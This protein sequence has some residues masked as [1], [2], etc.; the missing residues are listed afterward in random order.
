M[1]RT[2][3]INPFSGFPKTSE[4]VDKNG[5]RRFVV[6]PRAAGPLGAHIADKLTLVLTSLFAI[7]ALIG[8]LALSEISSFYRWALVAAPLPAFFAIRYVA[9][10][11]LSRTISVVF[12]PEIIRVRQFLFAKV[13][14]RHQPIKFVLRPFNEGGLIQK[15]AENR[16]K[17]APAFRYLFPAHD[18]YEKSHVLCLELMGQ[19]IDLMV[20]C[21][22][23]EANLICARLNAVHNSIDCYSGRGRGVAPTPSLDWS[24]EAGTLS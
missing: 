22:H 13:Y 9:Y 4:H 1:T 8:A 14:D 16:A 24:S 10:A 23:R 21:R 20:I 7:V 15:V 17:I 19:Q 12:T 6:K 18:Y 3:T 11:L 2:K 5:N